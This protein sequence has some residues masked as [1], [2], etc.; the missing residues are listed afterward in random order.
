MAPLWYV[1]PD[2]NL[3]LFQ[4]YYQYAQFRKLK[5]TAEKAFTVMSDS[6]SNKLM[7]L[8][9]SNVTSPGRNCLSSVW[10]KNKP[11]HVK[12]AKENDANV[13]IQIAHES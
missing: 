4:V 6:R 13:G 1:P 7:Q 5:N 8:S 11:N 3:L 10:E 12:V 2:Y 9:V